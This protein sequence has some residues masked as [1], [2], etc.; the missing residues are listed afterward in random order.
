MN[1]VEK[2]PD[3]INVGSG[4]EISI[5]DLAL[6]VQKTIGFLGKLKFDHN[7]PDGTLLKCIDSS[8]IIRRG[9]KHQVSLEEGITLIYQS[10]LAQNKWL[11]FYFIVD[12]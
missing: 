1:N 6:M 2:N 3:V 11:F 10:F 8:E 9:W 7:R 5:K 4:Q 12:I